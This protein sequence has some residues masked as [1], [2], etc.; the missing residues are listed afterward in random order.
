MIT[1]PKSVTVQRGDLVSKWIGQTTETTRR[2]INESKGGVMLIGEAFRLAQT[3]SSNSYRD[4]GRES[5]EELMRVMED[6]DPIMIFAGY[7]AEMASFLDFNPGM[8]SRI[9]FH[10]NFPDFSVSELASIIRNNVGNKGLRLNNQANQDLETTIENNSTKEQRSE[11]NGRLAR[12]VVTG[13][14]RDMYTRCYPGDIDGCSTK[15]THYVESFNNALLIYHDKRICFGKES[16]LL[17][18][19]LAVLDWEKKAADIRKKANVSTED[20][21]QASQLDEVLK[22]CNVRRQAYHGSAFVG[23]HVHVMLQI[24]AISDLSSVAAKVATDLVEKYD[25]FPLSIITRS[26]NLKEKY[27]QLFSLYAA[28][29]HSFTTA[30][31]LT[32]EDKSALD[33]LVA[34]VEEF[35][36][37]ILRVGKLHLEMNAAKSF[38]DVNFDT[39]YSVLGEEMEFK[40]EVAHRVA[41]NFADHHKTMQLIEIAIRVRQML[42]QYVR[43]K[44]QRGEQES[45]SAD[46]FL[47][48]W[49]PRVRNP[50]FVP[51]PQQINL[52]M[53]IQLTNILKKKNEELI[54]DM[55]KTNFVKRTNKSEMSPWTTEEG[56]VE[57]QEGP[58][59]QR[60]D[61]LAHEHFGCDFS[62]LAAIGED[63]A[64]CDMEGRDLGQD[65]A[66]LL[67][68]V[69]DA[70]GD[71]E[72]DEKD[73]DQQQHGPEHFVGHG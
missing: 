22:A 45:I 57:S 10:F 5:L 61:N 33:V 1:R 16:Y 38:V 20:G 42:V 32:E 72:E 27:Q 44:L 63:L 35:D 40:S 2:K 24:D 15:D 47:F 46:D 71:G 30:K 18:I 70:E 34:E 7:P 64:T 69:R 36:W 12:Q 14:V 66:V 3:N 58:E 54:S 19:N 53:D 55:E 50:N 21:P 11:M 39:L 43:G 26:R 41:R 59:Q 25:G 17:M 65:A 31:P 56:E 51:F 62:E 13:A 23:N 8:K 4:V 60:M 37:V 73:D 28:C 48:S 52:A 67:K 29:H 68:D 6:G 49:S 9:A